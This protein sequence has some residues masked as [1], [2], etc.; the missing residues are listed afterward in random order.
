MPIGIYTRLAPYLGGVSQYSQ[1]ILSSL[2]DRSSFIVN[3]KTVLFYHH[4]DQA[5]LP[6]SIDSIEDSVKLYTRIAPINRL[7]KETI[8]TFGETKIWNML[9]KIKHGSDDFRFTEDIKITDRRTSPYLTNLFRK[10]QLNW[11]FFTYPETVSFESGFPYIMPIHDL[12]HRLQP[13]FPEV[14]ASGRWVSREYLYRN[15]T[16]YATL[17]LAD[18]EVGKEDILNFYGQYGITP[19]RVKVLPYIP[20]SYLP[21]E[22]SKEDQERVINAYNL[23]N[24]YLFYPA[25][26]WPHKNHLRIVQAI[27]LIKKDKKIKVDVVFS[28]TKSDPIRRRVFKEIILQSHNLNITS[29]VHMLGYIPNYDM[30]SMYGGAASLIMPTFFGPTNI[31]ILEAWKFNCPVIT[32]DLRGIRE[33]VGEAG[34]IVDPRSVESIAAAIYKVWTDESLCQSLTKKGQDK[35]RSYTYDDFSQRLNQI[36]IEM[37]ERVIQNENPY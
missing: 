1:T 37:D 10:F 35:L 3:N 33:Q 8:N 26:F 32:S 9:R 2:F 30:A 21:D 14:S 22:S 5:Y 31:P 7:R 23:P 13:E 6:T 19:D 29:Q 17:I 27:G 28:G 36:L 20:A 34:L 15:G 18:S 4:G 12:Q 25:Q 11:I 16:R 24:R